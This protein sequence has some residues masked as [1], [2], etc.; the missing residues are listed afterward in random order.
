MRFG[1]SLGESL[2]ALQFHGVNRGAGNWYQFTLESEQLEVR[3]LP[4]VGGKIGQIRDKLTG[5]DFLIAPQ[6]PYKTIAADESWLDHDTSGID[7]CFPNVA[8]GPY[9]S[10]PWTGI[11]LPDL[12]EWTHETW[13]VTEATVCEVTLE[14][15]GSRLFYAGRK[16][17]S[18]R[19]D[20]SVELSYRL[21]NT[22]TSPFRYMWSAHPL[23]SVPGHFELILPPGEIE[24][25]TFPFDH[26]SHV[27][28]QFGGIDLSRS[29]LPHGKTLKIFLI[30]L[31][32]GWCA[33]RQPTCTLRF[34]FS[35]DTTPVLGIWLNNFG[36]AASPASPFRCIAIEPC[37]TASDLLDALPPDQ[38]PII[39]P[40]DTTEW[41]Y[42]VA[43]SN[44]SEESLSRRL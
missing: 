30:G 17:I 12:G 41:S 24:F 25:R 19:P 38:Y 13:R 42:R 23:I 21:E 11:L 29:C 18:V 2:P 22:G 6:R 36:F 33:L 40:G 20:R 7:D 32:Q 31:S 37:T 15:T 1:T 44:T 35:V 34:I 3:V 10:E 43:M 16:R 28:P 4:E 9:P 27:W 39:G 8:A 14:R 26:T 5:Y